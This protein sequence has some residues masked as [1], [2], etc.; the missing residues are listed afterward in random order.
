MNS[1]YTVITWILRLVGFLMMWIGLSM[2]FGP[3]TAVLDVL[4]FLGNIAEGMIGAVTFVVAFILS[5]ITILISII[6]HN[7]LVMIIVLALLVGGIYAWRQ[8][9]ISRA[10]VAA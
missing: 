4:P 6:L 7:I 9:Q 1:E 2:L 10:R 8:M 3:I 5:A